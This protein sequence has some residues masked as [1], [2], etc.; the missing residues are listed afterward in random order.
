M[1]QVSGIGAERA[2]Q[3]AVSLVRSG[4]RALVSWGTAG[5]LDPT[6][7][8]GSLVLPEVVVSEGHEEAAYACDRSWCTRLYARLQEVF[9]VHRGTITTSVGLITACEHK[10]HLFRARA[11]RAVDMES[12]AIA[13]VAERVGLPFV[14]IRVIAD[15]SVL[16]LPRAAVNALSADGHLRLLCMLRALARHPGDLPALLRLARSFNAA[17]RTLEAVARLAGPTLLAP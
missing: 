12:S 13:Q 7:T 9:D 15:S 10:A 6:L 17:C 1:L 4:T 16:A 2:A 3:A 11:A 5:G 8:P 14:A